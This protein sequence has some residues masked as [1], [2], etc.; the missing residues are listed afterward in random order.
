MQHG[1][2]I[3]QHVALVWQLSLT[4]AAI[5][6]YLA[7]IAKWSRRFIHLEDGCYHQF[8]L[9]LLQQQ[10]PLAVDNV[11]LF[12]EIKVLVEKGLVKTQRRDNK[13]WVMITEEG[14][15]WQEWGK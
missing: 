13:S 1:I 14:R 6:S 10:V 5:F 8:S 2:Y 4:Q 15:K 9:R 3:D 11:D 12:Y 7:S